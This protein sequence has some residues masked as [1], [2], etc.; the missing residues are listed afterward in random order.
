MAKI[1]TAQI[2]KFFKNIFSFE[3]DERNVGRTNIKIA[4]KDIAGT[5]SSNPIY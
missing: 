4:I 5:I 2:D 1:I 3:L